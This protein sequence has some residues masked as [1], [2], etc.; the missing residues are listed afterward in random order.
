MA[1]KSIAQKLGIKDGTALWT[2]HPDRIGGVIS[3]PDDA[4]VVKR[5]DRATMVLLFVDDEA[6]A[7]RILD[8]HAA[9]I[10]A[11]ATLWVAYPKGNRTDINRDSLW[12]IVAEHGMRPNQ[13][14]A[15]DERWSALRFRRLKEG[16]SQ[17]RGRA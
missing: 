2:S 1:T 17:F 8:E 12:P 5:I 14:V 9:A 11:D 3:M 15:I 13:Q 7:R 6:S 4:S 16:E 10:P